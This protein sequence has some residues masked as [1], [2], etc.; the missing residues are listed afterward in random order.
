MREILIARAVCRNWNSLINSSLQLRRATIRAPVP[1]HF[2]SPDP[3]KQC[4]ISISYWFTCVTLPLTSYDICPIFTSSKE[5]RYEYTQKKDPSHSVL[6]EPVQRQRMSISCR[7]ISEI[8][9]NKNQYTILRSMFLTQPSCTA[10]ELGVK[11]TPKSLS[12]IA[13]RDTKGI[14]IGLVADVAAKAH[15]QTR[16]YLSASDFDTVVK[17]PVDL[18]FR[19]LL[20]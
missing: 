4:P 5:N 8:A 19:M 18:W 20:E 1:G 7:L 11:Q 16:T 14:T 13:L 15:S 9:N 10:I 2:I 3:A 6:I 17:A 12:P